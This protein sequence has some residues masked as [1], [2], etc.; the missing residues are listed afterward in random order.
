MNHPCKAAAALL[1]AALVGALAPAGLGAQ[2]VTTGAIGG[3]VTGAG[4]APLAGANVTV[5]H[6]PSGTRYS[7]AT[8]ADGRFQIPGMRVGGPYTVSVSALGYAQASRSDVTV[9][10]GVLTDVPFAL[11]EAALVL[12]GLT[13]TA[14]TQAGVF[15]PDRTG[16]ATTVSREALE[17]LPTVNRRIEDFARLTPQA[18]PG[19]SFAG[20]DNRLNNI[21]VDGSYFNNSFGLAGVPGQRTGV[22]PI[23]LDAVEQVQVNIAPFDVR[24][25]NFVGASVNTVT[26]SGGNQLRGSLRY[27]FRNQGMVGGS[28]RGTEVST[29]DFDFRN[30][31]GWLSGP[32]IQNRLFFFVNYENESRTEPGTTFLANTG[33][34]PV[35]GNTTRV[36]ASDL[37]GLSTF[38]RTNFGYETGPYQGYDHSTPATRFLAKLDYNVNDRNR[39]S[40]RYNHLD[41]EADIL[42]SNSSSLGFGTRRSNLSGLNFRGSNYTIMENIR[43]LV[44]EWNAQIGGNMANNLIVGFT[45]QDESR[46]SPGELFPFVD[47]LSGSSVYTSFG[48]EPFTPSNELRYS[49]FQLQNNFTRFGTRHTQTFGVS[50]ERYESENI[51]FPGSQSAYVYNSLADFYADAN[52]YLANPNRLVSP[53][54]LRR[55]QVRWSNIPGQ[56]KP[57]QPL[58]VLYGGVYAQNEFRPTA[59]LTLMGGLRIDVPRFGN[60][61]YTNADADALTFRDENGANVRYSTGSLP[62]AKPLFSPR[63]GFNWDPTGNRVTQIRGGTGVFTGRPAYVWISNQIGNTGVLTGF[64]RRDGT[65]AAPLTSRPFHPNPDHYKPQTVTGAPASQYELALTDPNFRFPQVWRTNIAVD[66]RLPLGLIGT[67]EFLYGRD[68]NGV[69]Y[70]NANLAAPNG[71]FAGPDPR[72][73]WVG[74]N[75]NRIHTNVDNAV[76]LKNQNEGTSWNLSGSLERPFGEGIFAKVAY[77]YGEARNT[78]DPGS[79]AFGSWNNNQHAG[80][81]NNPG[82]GF[83][84]NSPGHRVFAALSARRDWFR[85]GGTS[86]SL[87]WEGRTQGNASYVYG[88]DLNGDGGTSNDLIYIPASMA[89]MNFVT[90]TV[91]VS[92]QSITFTPQQQA[93]AFEAFIRQDRYLSANRGRVA[94]RGAVFMPMV[95]RMDFSIAQQVF[96]NV[97]GRRHGLELRADVLNFGN[98]LNDQ[99]GAGYRFTN[100][101]PLIPQGVDATGQPRFHF[102]QS[103]GALIAESFQRTTGPN[104][105]YQIQLGLRYTF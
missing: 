14:E 105:L 28:T 18:S 35:E 50:L 26:R 102:R 104:D 82:L 93:E 62:A 98:W 69:Y 1:F 44:G 60:T 16:A 39:L 63:F 7:G 56:D 58:E 68:V 66:Q 72:P 32:I 17:N 51:F 40:L 20:A 61:A 96:T 90:Q 6:V 54:N 41:S 67:G 30:L 24:Q 31:G 36:L 103:G 100:T 10:L 89:E 101:Q 92:G 71:T 86:F 8:R 65:P 48:S 79:I 29:G 55:F 74:T 33:G 4:G 15:S 97:S 22:A 84:A 57:V 73:R 78:V 27:D 5:V 75:A 64:E 47:I 38:L 3:T 34:Q 99:W 19:L 21:T 88:G 37:D 76:V 46:G 77:S 81:P 80:D 49:S 42:L 94:E 2:G 23:S 13:V 9:N 59:T 85:F 52:H 45:S 12:E 43:S 70:I 91:T 25:G 87:F 53:V 11:Q 95:Y 83:S